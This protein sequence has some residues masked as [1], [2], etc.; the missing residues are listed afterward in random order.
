[1]SDPLYPRGEQDYVLLTKQD[2]RSCLINV[3]S[4]SNNQEWFNDYF[5][6][7]QDSKYLFSVYKERHSIL[8]LS[9]I[10]QYQD[11]ESSI[12]LINN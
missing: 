2:N 4:E 10:D 3:K 8:N 12:L 5:V 7:K 6:V 11:D 1:M 9:N